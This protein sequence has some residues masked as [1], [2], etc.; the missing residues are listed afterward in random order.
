MRAPARVL[1]GRTL[2]KRGSLERGV[3]L[4]QGCEAVVSDGIVVKETVLLDRKRGDI[5]LFSTP[6]LAVQACGS[7]GKFIK[8][9]VGLPGDVWEERGGFVYINGKKLNEPYVKA[10]RRDSDSLT[11]REIP[12]RN[13]YAQIP[14]GY[15]LMMGD[16][17]SSSC[18]SRRWGFVPKLNLIGKVV[19]ILRPG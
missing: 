8:R 17:R 3:S 14:K 11:L 1:V 4:P 5:V 16:N 7:G 13:T 2:V 10:N 9:V 12:P 19:Q 15:Y 6:H 18:D